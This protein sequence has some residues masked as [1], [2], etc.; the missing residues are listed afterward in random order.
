LAT[1]T[2]P[3]FVRAKLASYKVPKQIVLVDEV[4]RA[5]NGKPDYG[6]ACKI[7]EAALA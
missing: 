1:H 3:Q 7:V 5:T 4:R 6:W 2:Y